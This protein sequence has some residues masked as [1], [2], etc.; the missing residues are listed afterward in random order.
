M[1]Q[2]QLSGLNAINDAEQIEDELQK[3]EG[4]ETCYV[5]FVH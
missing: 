5:D 1:Q 3:I 2:Y 4:L